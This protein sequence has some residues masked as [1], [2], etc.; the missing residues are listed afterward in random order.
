MIKP[1]LP[2][3]VIHL[4]GG[5]VRVDTF[6][7]IICFLRCLKA[8]MRSLLF[9]ALIIQFRKEFVHQI[10]APRKSSASEPLPRLTWHQLLAPCSSGLIMVPATIYNH[11]TSIMTTYMLLW[12]FDVIWVRVGTIQAIS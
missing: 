8:C 4:G 2:I 6:T 9:H 10:R 11:K 12:F 3:W 5:G 7:E 1:L